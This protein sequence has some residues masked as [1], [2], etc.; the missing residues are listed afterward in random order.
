MRVAFTYEDA[1]S[2]KY[3]D[4]TTNGSGIVYISCLSHLYIDDIIVHSSRIGPKYFEL[5]SG[6]N[7]DIEPPDPPTGVTVTPV[8]SQQP[9]NL[10]DSPNSVVPV[11]LRKTSD[12]LSNVRVYNDNTDNTKDNICIVFNHLIKSSAIKIFDPSDRLVYTVENYQQPIFYWFGFD[13]N[14]NKVHPGEYRYEIT[15]GADAVAGKIR[16]E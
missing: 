16:I 5:L 13:R 4:L 9:D 11:S 12:S 1:M 8:D 6:N 10:P 15:C 14:G 2:N 3:I 7:P